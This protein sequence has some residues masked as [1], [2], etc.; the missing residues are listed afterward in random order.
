MFILFSIFERVPKRQVSI[1]YFSLYNNYRDRRTQNFDPYCTDQIYLFD[2]IRYLNIFFLNVK[3]KNYK[4]LNFDT[5][6]CEYKFWLQERLFAM[7]SL[8]TIL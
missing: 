5:D 4:Q 8:G 7:C 6:R 1:Y 2:S 3:V